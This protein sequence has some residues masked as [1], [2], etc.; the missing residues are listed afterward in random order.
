VLMKIKMFWDITPCS[1]ANNNRCF[2]WA[3]CLHRQSM[4]VRVGSAIS[5]RLLQQCNALPTL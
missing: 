4:A 5:W 2:G 1:F 3:C